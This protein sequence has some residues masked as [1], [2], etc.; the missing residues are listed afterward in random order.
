MWRKNFH[1]SD[2]QLLAQIDG[3][4]SAQDEKLARSH[5]DECPE[6]RA[7]RQQLADAMADFARVHQAAFDAAIPRRDAPRSLL[8]AQLRQITEAETESRRIWPGFGYRVAAAAA[9]GGLLA[10]AVV[11]MGIRRHDTK[12]RTMAVFSLPDSSLTPGATIRVDQRV[13]CAEASSGNKTVPAAVQRQVF[14]E[15]RI[16]GADPRAYEVDYLITPALGGAD[17]IRNL[18]PHSYS[19]TIWNA[20][21]KDALENH[22]R[23]LVCGGNLDLG[24]A[25]REIATNWIAAY[26]KYFG[27]DEPLPEHRRQQE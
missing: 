6:C 16:D 20:R 14:E 8:R 2:E 9:I 11:S 7:R 25:Q 12:R 15:Y 13:V 27:A 24:E 23:D 4:S 19:A 26:K 3:E 22:L 1:L 5:L 10:L 17:D 21:I 18:W